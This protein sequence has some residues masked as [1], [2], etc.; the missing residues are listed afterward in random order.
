MKFHCIFH[1]FFFFFEYG[2]QIY[3]GWRDTIEEPP[4]KDYDTLE[5][6]QI[7]H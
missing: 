2:K 7:L 4:M 6:I 5:T 3:K 1:F